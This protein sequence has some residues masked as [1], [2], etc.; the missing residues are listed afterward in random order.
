MGH[1]CWHKIHHAKCKG[2][3]QT[4]DKQAMETRQAFWSE[5]NIIGAEF[6]WS[7][8]EATTTKIRI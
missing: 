7:K 6:I 5:S 2:Q 3:S 4:Y 8:C 1:N